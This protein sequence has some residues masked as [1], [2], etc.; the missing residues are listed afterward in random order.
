MTRGRSSIALLIALVALLAMPAGALA[1]AVSAH[2]DPVAELP[3]DLITRP[4]LQSQWGTLPP[5]IGIDNERSGGLPETFCGIERT[6]DNTADAAP[7]PTDQQ[8]KLIYA[9]ASDQPDRFDALKNKLQASVSLLTRYLAGQSGGAK[10]I[11]FDL[12]TNCGPQYVDI[13]VVPLP[14]PQSYYVVSGVPQF[15]RLNDDVRAAANLPPGSR[16]NL[17]VYADALRGTDGVGGTGMRYTTPGVADVPDASNPHNNGD[18]LSV[19]WGPTTVPA[20]SYATPATLMHELSHNL[21]AVQASAPHTTD[22]S[23]GGHCTDE[24]DLMCYA[25][26]GPNNTLTYTC[27]Y[28]SGQDD[29]FDPSPA[30]SSYLDTHWNVF[31]SEHLAPC[32]EADAT[33]SCGNADTT[34]PVNTT[35]APA[36]SWYTA[37]YA[38]AL[39][40]TDSES[41]VDHMEWQVDGGAVNEVG[42]GDTVTIS[43]SGIHTLSTRAVD[44]AGNASSWRNDTVKVDVTKPTDTTD[45]GTVNWRGTTA[46]VTVTAVD[47]AS[48]V[49]H[50]EWRLDGGTI[51]TDGN[52]AV[53]N[54]AGDG[55]HTLSTRAVDVAG[56]ISDWRNHTIRIDTVTPVDD[57]AFSSGWHTSAFM[58]SV[59]GSDAHSGIDTLTYSVDGSPPTTG[60]SPTS[61][62]LSNEGE[63]T[64]TTRVKDVAGNQTGWKTHTVRIDTTAPSNLT[65]PSDE[66][67]TTADYQVDVKASDQTSGIAEVQWRVDGNAYLSGASGSR[68]TVAGTGDHIFE[69]R[70]RDV[71]GN[72]SGWRSEHVRIDRVLPTNTTIPA[73]SSPVG[74]PYTVTVSGTDAHSGVDHVEWKV[75]GGATQTSTTATISGNGIHTLETRVVDRAGNATPWRADTIEVDAVSG[76]ATPPT[77]T[78]TTAPTG[79]RTG[80]IPVTVSATD[81]GSG[82]DYLEWRLDSGLVKSTQNGD[83]PTFVISGDGAHMLETRAADHAGRISGWREQ[84]FKIDGSLPSDDTDIPAGWSDSA[85][86]TLDGSDS[87]SDIAEIEYRV[88]TSGPYLHG[89]VGQ[90]LTLSGDGEYVITHRAIDLAGNATPRLTETLKVDTTLPTNTSA[91]PASTWTT[92]PIELTLSGTDATSGLDKMQWRVDGGDIHDGGPAIVDTDGEHVLET[93]AVDVAG[94]ASAWR[95]DTVRVDTTAPQNTTAAVPTGWISTPYDVVVTGD[96]GAGSGLDTIE[97]KVDGVII[98]GD[99]T[100]VTGD[101]NHTVETRLTDDLGNQ[102]AWR[103]D[104]VKIDTVVPTATLTCAA[105]SAW[106]ARAVACTPVASGGPSGLSALT[107]SRNGG[108]PAAVTTGRAVSIATDG[109]HTLTLKAVDGAGNQKVVTARVKVDR[110]NPAVSLGCV[111]ASTP[112]G[113]VCRA[114]GSDRL[115]GL[116]AL[117]YSVNGG[118]WTALPSNGTFTVASGS[119]RVLARDAAGNQALT[120]PVTLAARTKPVVQVQDPVTV[121]SS[122]KPVYL[123]GHKDPDSLVGALLAARSPNGTVSIDLRPLAVGRGKF[124]VQIKLTSGKHR[125][126]VTKTYKVGRGGTLP[127]IAAS[128]SKATEKATVQLTV[129]KTSGRKWKRYATSKVVLAK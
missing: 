57:T 11:R 13:Q 60:A 34:P 75:D 51:H 112:T 4:V 22:S 39:S 126:T 46:D 109:S 37:P 104:H 23:N 53:V 59:Q 61:V 97:L 15:N 1:Q 44:E 91:V 70:A 16:R 25:D 83:T 48:G 77:D 21:G 92:D 85:T 98:A 127:R 119:V 124:K 54:V 111:A 58:V 69:T 107:L 71:A 20:G 106:N 121:R 18:L 96:D 76:D 49:D 52:G 24:Q 2:S 31:N 128:L 129:S 32:A 6:D 29:Y 105:S 40:G 62:Q 38:V 65:T 90:Q 78:T 120:A 68:A 10:T 116:A 36:T 103:V 47:P 12:G 27:D 88:G 102:S 100:T 81:A 123:A 114:S 35:P 43:T 7:S 108:A 86:V 45:P 41:G 64:M 94:N 118:A 113:Y 101:G 19:V 93:R 14:S 26:G 42:N 30:P 5:G 56:N 66:V 63:Y 122:S 79:W 8:F 28:R 17:L 95:A 84:T 110:T 82:V 67:W 33:L 3:D 73:P 80:A 9:Y 74:N 99:H 125:R 55:N 72:Y 117:F 115:S 87:V 50:I 89:T